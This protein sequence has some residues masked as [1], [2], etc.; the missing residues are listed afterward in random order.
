MSLFTQI[1]TEQQK[2]KDIQM[3]KENWSG[4]INI[5]KSRFQN[6]IRDKEGYFHDNHVNSSRICKNYSVY[7]K[8]YMTIY[9]KWKHSLKH[10]NNK[11]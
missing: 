7:I 1:F 6:I 3:L 5:R 10:K 11:K 9:M 2:K 8:M 4:N